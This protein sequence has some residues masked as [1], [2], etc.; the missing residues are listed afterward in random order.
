MS[1][2]VYRVDFSST[3]LSDLETMEVCG[4]VSSQ[5]GNQKHKERDAFSAQK[6]Q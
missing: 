6:R 4:T 5:N 3:T 1:C 2:K